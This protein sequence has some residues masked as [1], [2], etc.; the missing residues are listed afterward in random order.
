ME[1]VGAL[2]LVLAFC[3]ALYAIVG[4][5]VGRLKRRPFLI[6]SAERAVY[7]VWFLITVAAGILV[8]A[9]MTSDF[10]F[11]YAAGHSNRDM[12]MLYKITAWWGGQE[13]SLLFWSWLLATYSAVVVFTNRRKF[14]DMM[15]YVVA[16]MSTIQ[17]FFLILNAFLLSPFQMLA[18]DKVVTSV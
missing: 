2:A 18:V 12:P 11:A 13:G 7:S 10:R 8:Y 14:R 6:V 16:V 17:G 1:N 5:V 4:S 9:L 15:P 3:V